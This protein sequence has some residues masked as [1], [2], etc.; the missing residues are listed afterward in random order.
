VDGK[1]IAGISKALGI[2]QGTIKAQLARGRAK[3]AMLLR[4]ELGVQA[5]AAPVK[6]T[7]VAQ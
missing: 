5:S 2:P 1:S 4:R 7:R 6:K 3:L